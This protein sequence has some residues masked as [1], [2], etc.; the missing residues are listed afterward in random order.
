MLQR[1]AENALLM[2]FKVFIVE[3]EEE[4]NK[5]SL[6]L[7]GKCHNLAQLQGF[8][9]KIAFDLGHNVWDRFSYCLLQ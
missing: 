5:E 9:A 7:S 8:Y 2:L 4:K 3:E 1:T 6:P